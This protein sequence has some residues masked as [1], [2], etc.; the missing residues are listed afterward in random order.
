MPEEMIKD[1]QLVRQDGKNAKTLIVFYEVSQKTVA[2]KLGYD[3]P[4][5]SKILSNDIISDDELDK[6]AK[7]IHPH[8]T[9][10]CI[11]YYNHENA[12]QIIIQHLHQTVNNGGKAYNAG[13]KD[14]STQHYNP[15]QEVMEINEKMMQLNN[16]LN[17][18]EKEIMYLR[19][20]YEPEKV[21][22]EKNK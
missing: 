22:A 6:I 21:E 14:M 13:S 9:G 5:L 1:S 3:E 12:K 10:D 16:K 20:K 18:A 8:L 4:K 7:A 2:E 15:L 19:M 11:K 17:T